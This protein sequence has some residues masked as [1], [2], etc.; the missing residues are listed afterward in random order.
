MSNEMTCEYLVA[1]YQGFFFIK[2]MAEMQCFPHPDVSRA[3]I[4]RSTSMGHPSV[5]ATHGHTP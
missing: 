1:M 5:G 3:Q 2:K 4:Y